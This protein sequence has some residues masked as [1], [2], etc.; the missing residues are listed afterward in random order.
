MV[1]IKIENENKRKWN[2]DENGSTSV[3]SPL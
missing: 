1:D 2:D 3:T